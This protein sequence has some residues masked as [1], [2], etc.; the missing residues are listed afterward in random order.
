[1][2]T[3]DKERATEL[4]EI[5]EEE[6][7]RIVR[8]ALGKFNVFL[9]VTAFLTGCAYLALLGIFV[10]KTMPYILIPIGLWAVG[11]AYHFWRAWHPRDATREA[12][13]SLDEFDRPVFTPEREF[14]EEEQ[15][16]YEEGLKFFVEGPGEASDQQDE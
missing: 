10:P 6:R 9:H 2:D 11:L 12:L 3:E 16:L 15:E 14:T 8:E 7:Q 4:E 1:M 13:R 5:D